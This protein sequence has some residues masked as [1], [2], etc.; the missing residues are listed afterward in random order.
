MA[1]R[2]ALLCL[3]GALAFAAPDHRVA[4]L[5][6][7]L[8]GLDPA[9]T[10][11]AEQALRKGGFAV[12][13]IDVARLG[14]PEE[15]NVQHFDSLA[16][17]H[18]HNLTAAARDNLLAFLKSGGD[19]V[20]LGGRGFLQ[21]G[22]MTL[23]AF[24][25][26]EA[27][28]MTGI[29]SV[30]EFAGQPLLKGIRIA[31]T[32]EGTS[33]IGFS[34]RVAKFTPLLSA[35][36]RHGRV[37]GWAA[38]LL[39]HFDEY[40]GSDWLLFG[41]SNPEFYST[42]GFAATLAAILPKMAGDGLAREAKA[43]QDLAVATRIPLT[44]PAPK[45]FLRRSADGKHI[46]HPDGRRFF[47]VGMNYHRSLD[48]GEWFGKQPFD[49]VS[50]EDDFRKARDAGVNCIRLGTAG[51]FYEKPEVVRECARRY[52][53]YLLILLNWGTRQDFVENAERVAQM[54]KDEPMV[55]GYDIQN[56]PTPSAVAGLKYDG[57]PSPAFRLKAYDRPTFE[58]EWSQAMEPFTRGSYSTFPGL[59]SGFEPAAP[60]SAMARALND[61]YELWIGKH[62]AAIRKHD[63]N[64]LISVGYNTIQ[65]VL[66]ANRRLDFVS[67]HVYEWPHSYESV[68]YNLTTMDRLAKLWPDK[69]VTLGEFGYTN[70]LVMSD[71]RYLDFHTSA[72]G[73]MAHYLYALARGYDGVMKWVLTDW[74]WDVIA[75]AGDRGRATQIYEAY[76]GLYWYD[77]N[78]KGM[79]RLKPVGH[80]MKFLRDYWDEH[81][82]GGT[83]EIRRAR[84]PIGAGY[85]FRAPAALFIGDSRYAG[86][87]LSF[88]AG[89]PANVMLTWNDKSLTLM[90]TCDARVEVDA[91]KF[92]PAL[93]SRGKVALNLLEGK[94]VTVR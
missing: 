50:F 70:G 80:A 76:F 46:V 7:N 67:H 14:S 91:A 34:R 11:A 30:S 18:S 32:F 29:T 49:E 27:Y 35:N 48:Q 21:R 83:I 66:P 52:G 94:R 68:M 75:K 41:I 1:F 64:H 84:N 88:T 62:I 92:V 37:R 13:P 6:D 73:E 71:G 86:E 4:V 8:P 61:T 45:G 59:L 58:K 24:S 72:V 57:E 10:A 54:Y 60:H 85:V 39:S 40:P 63:P 77:G 20:M 56:E 38:G 12:S 65:T 28:R 90:S 79:G 36:D 93:A 15:F 43:A 22:S 87:G 26:Y 23:A 9:V 19:L 53:I 2:L 33:A 89:S 69:P 25:R 82:P 3:A 17:D 16:L 42:P 5:R 47:M 31:G 74:H 55:L 44:S 51:H 81:G 78:P